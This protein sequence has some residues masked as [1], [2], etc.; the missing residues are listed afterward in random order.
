MITIESRQPDGQLADYLISK[1]AVI[2]AEAAS[3]IP[4]PAAAGKGA[5]RLTVDAEGGASVIDLASLAGVFVNGER[6]V[7]YGPLRVDDA[8]MVAANVHNRLGLAPA[9]SRTAAASSNKP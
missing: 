6:I 8:I 7:R 3:P 4:L 1:T 2:G 5:L 9:L